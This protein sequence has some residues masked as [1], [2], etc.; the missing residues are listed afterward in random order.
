MS[1]ELKAALQRNPNYAAAL[2]LLGMAELSGGDMKAALANLQRA[3][4]LCPRKDRYYLN[5][6]RAYEAAGNLDAARNLMQ[7]AR[8]GQ[9]CGGP[10]QRREKYSANS[11]T[12]KSGNNNGRRWE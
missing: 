10:R 2:E 3:S 11:A 1:T 6:A 12:K 8:A 7:Y 9:R 4:A 5:L